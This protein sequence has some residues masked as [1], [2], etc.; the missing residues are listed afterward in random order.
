MAIAPCA[1]SDLIVYLKE[2]ASIILFVL[3]THHT[4]L[5]E[6]YTGTLCNSLGLCKLQYLLLSIYFGMYVKSVNSYVELSHLEIY[7]GIFSLLFLQNNVSHTYLTRTF[8]TIQSWLLTA[9]LNKPQ[10]KGT[11]SHG[12]LKD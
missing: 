11:N 3:T 10:L 4:P 8:N 1:F 7:A 9:S 6:S 2:T 5:S 12:I